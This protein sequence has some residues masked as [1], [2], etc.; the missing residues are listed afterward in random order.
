MGNESFS[1]GILG[2]FCGLWEFV[3]YK[4]ETPDK[5][6]NSPEHKE[7]SDEIENTEEDRSGKGI[8]NNCH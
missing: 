4:T 1:R 6:A 5:K 8:L 7:T 3:V 2:L